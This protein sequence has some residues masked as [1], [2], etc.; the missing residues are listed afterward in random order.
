M[1]KGIS[2]FVTFCAVNANT[3]DSEIK[4]ANRKNM[5]GVLIAGKN[6]KKFFDDSETMYKKLKSNNLLIRF[7]QGAFG[8]QIPANSYTYIDE[9]VKSITE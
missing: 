3:A 8:H 7:E 2:G 1:S 9:A 5:K 6:D 4:I